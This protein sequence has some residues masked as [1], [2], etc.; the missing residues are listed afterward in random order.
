MVTQRISED[1]CLCGEYLCDQTKALLHRPE[2]AGAGVIDGYSYVKE[3]VGRINPNW[4]QHQNT[5]GPE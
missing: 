2:D 1:I 4:F 5:A 3:L